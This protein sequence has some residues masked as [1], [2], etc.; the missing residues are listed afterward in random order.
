[1]TCRVYHLVK[2]L[3]F[4]QDNGWNL[5][6]LACED[7]ATATKNA[8][9]YQNNETDEEAPCLFSDHSSGGYA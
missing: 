7:S 4:R 1:M 8:K 9:H 3:P 5:S 6:R 2:F